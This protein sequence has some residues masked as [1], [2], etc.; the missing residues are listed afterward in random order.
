MWTVNAGP[1][2]TAAAKGTVCIDLTNA[3]LYQNVDGGTTWIPIGRGQELNLGTLALGAA[4][5]DWAPPGY[6]GQNVISVA[7]STVGGTTLNGLNLGAWQVNGF[8]LVL[9]NTGALAITLA[10]ENAGSVATNRFWTVGNASVQRGAV[11]L[12][13]SYAG[14]NARWQ[15]VSRWSAAS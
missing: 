3:A 13:Y 12:R 6:A 8:D 10:D 2:T 15:A 4:V 14:A 1:P 5:N 7:T 11:R 9:I